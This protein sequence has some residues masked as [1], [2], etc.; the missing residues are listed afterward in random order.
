[1]DFVLLMHLEGLPDARASH[2]QFKI[3][4]VAVETVLDEAAQCHAV[5]NPH[6][7]LMVDFHH[8]AVVGANGEVGQEVVF[9]FEP[10]VY[11]FFYNVLINHCCYI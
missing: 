3:F 10:R 9:P 8:D 4:F 6:T 7:V 11:Q 1:M 2:F 5:F